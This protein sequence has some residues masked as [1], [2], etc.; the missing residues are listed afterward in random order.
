MVEPINCDDRE[1]IREYHIR[2]EILVVLFLNASPYINTMMVSVLDIE[3]AVPTVLNVLLLVLSLLC[4]I[5]LTLYFFPM[6]LIFVRIS[7]RTL[8]VSVISEI[9]RHQ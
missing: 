7:R 9:K 1:H 5:M 4:L 2:N 6:A 8:L 3:L